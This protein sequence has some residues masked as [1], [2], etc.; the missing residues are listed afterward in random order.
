MVETLTERS[1]LEVETLS[2]R[3]A[4]VDIRS[5]VEVLADRLAERHVHTLHKTLAEV[6]LCTSDYL[7]G[8]HK[9]RSNNLTTHCPSSRRL[10]THWPG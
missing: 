3:L 7:I 9:C 8:Y 10:A 5:L 4:K 2:K 6:R 1:V